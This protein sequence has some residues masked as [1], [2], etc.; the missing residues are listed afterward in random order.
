MVRLSMLMAAVLPLLSALPCQAK[1]KTH[2]ET[3]CSTTFTVVWKD[4]LGNI[5]QGLSDSTVKAIRKKLSKEYPDVCYVEPDPSVALVFYVSIS[6]STYH[7]SRTVTSQSAAPVS[8][9]ITDPSGN[10]ST[11]S[12]TE[13]STTSSSEPVEFDYPVALLSI[14][15]RQPDKTF[16]VVHRVQRKGL[17]PTYFGVCIANRHPNI[18]LIE[19][20]AKWLHDGGLT[21]PLEGVAE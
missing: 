10:V 12:G 15:V 18:S 5:K 21:N 6:S 19:D 1:T 2:A 13:T 9:T 7:G 3:S 8:G 20:A 16:K 14:E 4:Q 11:I 17:C